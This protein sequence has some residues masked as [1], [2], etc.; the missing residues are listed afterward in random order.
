MAVVLCVSM[1]PVSAFAE[2][3]VA[4]APA[5]EV[6]E[7]T[8][9]PELT[10]PEGTS[11]PEETSEPEET[12]AT[13]AAEAT[14]SPVTA[15]EPETT[16][17]EETTIP[18]ETGDV[19]EPEITWTL[20]G[21]RLP[22]KTSYQAGDPI[23]LTGM[24][25]EL[26]S[27]EGETLTV[28]ADDGITIV[29]GSTECSGIIPV[30]VEYAGLTVEFEILVHM[31]STVGDV[32]QDSSGYPESAHNYSNNMNKT[33]VYS[34]AGAEYLK[35]TFS[36]STLLESGYDNIYI[37]DGA[38]VLLGTYSGSSLA[39]QTIT[40][41]GN[42]VKIRLKTDGSVTKYGFSLTSIYA[43][44]HLVEH[45]PVDEGI[46]TA[47]LCYV[48][49]Y[50][51][52]TC[53][54]CGE[55]FVEP[56]E[57]SACHVYAG[58]FCTGC[59]IPENSIATGRLTDT[60]T[61]AMT[62][63]HVLYVC[64]TGEIPDSPGW[65]ISGAVSAVIS[66][67]V[68]RIGSKAFYGC[69]S[70]TEVSLPASLTAIG[71]YAFYNCA[72][73]TEITIPT[74]VTSLPDYCFQSCSALSRVTLPA[75]LK[76][77]GNYVFQYCTSLTSLVL[78]EGITSLGNSVFYGCSA[79]TELRLPATLTTF[80]YSSSRG[81]LDGSG[82]TRV[83]FGD[84]FTTIPA[85]AL[86]SY[87][88]SGTYASRIREV[89]FED[90]S[91]IT[92]IGSYAFQN[93]TALTEI[94]LP[95]GLKSLGNYAFYNCTSLTAIA[96]PAGVTSLPDYCFQS[97]SALSRVTLPAG[98]KSLGN[99]V[100]PYCTSLTSIVLPEGIT[101]L[102]NSVFYGCS[103]LTELR[104]PATLTTFGRNGARGPL[105]GSGITKVIFGD[106]FTTIPAYALSN[107]ATSGTY[108]SRIREV[109]FEDASRITSIGSYA[110]QN[111]VALTTITIPEAVM[112]IPAYAFY[113]CTSL[114]EA[115]LSERI[116]SIG[117][118][119]F[120]NCTALTELTIPAGMSVGSYAFGYCSRLTEL[121]IG[122]GANIGSYAFQSCSSLR[123][124]VIGSNVTLGSNAFYGVTL[125]GSCGESMTYSLNVS[126]GVLTLS[127]SG[128][129]TDYAPDSPAP[130]TCL[131][132]TITEISFGAD[133]TDIGDY[134]LTG[135]TKLEYLYLPESIQSVGAN[136][137]E[138]CTGLV[139]L[140]I[141]DG[142]SFIGEEAFDGCDN[143]S[144]A[145]FLGDAPVLQDNVFGEAAVEVS[146]PETSA[147]SFV[148][149][150]NKFVQYIW[151]KW[152]DTVPSKDVVILLDVSGSMSGKTSTLSSASTQL[153]KAICGATKKTRVSIVTYESSAT[154]RAGFSTNTHYL[155][156]KVAS[157]NASGGTTYSNA[158]NQAKSLLNSSD[159]D[160]RFVIMF[161]D[162]QPGDSTATINSIASGMRDSGIVMYSVGLGTNSTQRQVLIDVAGSASRYFEA[163]N[164]AGL[165][166]AFQE[167]SE[168]FGKSEYST[169]EMKINDKRVDLFKETYTMVLASGES[170]S[171]YV[172]L[173]TNEMYE[174]VAG[175][176][177]EQNGRYVLRGS[178]G[179]FTN[180]TPASYFVTGSPV[181]LVLLDANGN[182]IERK[183]LL[184][185]FVDSYTIRY[186]MGPD[187]GNELYR[188][189]TFVPGAQITPPAP[190]TRI[191]YDFMGWYSSENCEGMDFFS[192]LELL[193][194]QKLT[195]N[196]TVYA[197][198]QTQATE[199]NLGVDTWTFGN[200]S[201]NFN[202][203]HYEMTTNDVQRLEESAYDIPAE[204]IRGEVY[205]EAA[206]LY[207]L[208]HPTKYDANRNQMVNY[209]GGSCFGMSSAVLLADYGYL[210]ISRF[211]ANGTGGKI[212]NT[213]GAASLVSN[214]NGDHDVGA[215]ESMINFYQT[216][217]SL[218][219]INSVRTDYTR[220]T[221]GTD[222][223]NLQRIIRKLKAENAPVLMTIT[224]LKP[225]NSYGGHAIVAYD[226]E[227]FADRYSFK[228]YDC[229]QFGSRSNP[230]YYTVNV[231]VDGD[232][233]TATC[234]E[235]TSAWSRSGYNRIFFKTA[236]TV[237]EL[238]AL[239][240]LVQPSTL[241]PDT[242]SSAGQNAAQY[243]LMTNYGNFT[244][245][246]GTCSAVIENGELISGDLSIDCLGMVN[247]IDAAPEYWFYLPALNNGDAY[248]ITH[249]VASGNRTAL[250][251]HHQT[252]GFYVT[253]MAIGAG[254]IT[255]GGDGSIRSQYSG[256]VTQE[257][258]VT[259]NN[260]TTPWYTV[261]ISGEGTGFALTPNGD[262][263]SIVSEE[264]TNVDVTAKSS[265]NDLTLTDVP[266]GTAESIVQE[267]EDSCVVVKDGQITAGEVYGY[268]VAFNSQMGTNVPTLTNVPY[269]ALI[270]EPTDPTKTGCIFEGWFV[271]ES[272]TELWD[273]ASDTV[274]G[275]T[276]LYAGWSVNPNYLKAVT[277]RLPGEEDQIVYVPK[278][279]LIP[280]EYAPVDE[281]GNAMV[282]YTRSDFANDPWDFDTDA[283]TGDVVLYG[284]TALCT[285][286]YEP[287]NGAYLPEVQVYAGNLITA[288][289]A[290]MEGR[291][292]CG[293]YTDPG[294][295]EQWDF[296]TDRVTADMTLYAKWVE[297]IIDREGKDTGIS[298]EIVNEA[299]I[300]YTGKAV[301]PAIIVRDNGKVLTEK[302]D[303][304]VSFKNNTAACS[305]DD[306]DVKAN[307]LP[308]IIVQGKGNYK[309]SGKITQYFT[310][311]RADIRTLQIALPTIVTVKSGDKLQTLKPTVS[312]A[313]A[314]VN[315]K[316]YT[317]RYFNDAALTGEVSGITAAGTYY[318]V[319]D[320]TDINLTG[321]SDPIRVLAVTAD[322]LLSK[323]RIT[324]PKSILS[325][326][327]ALSEDAAIQ[328]LV[329][330]VVLNKVTW[331]TAG[332]DLEQ[333]KA[334]FEVTALDADGSFVPQAELGRLLNSVGKKTVTVTAREGNA[335]GLA[336]EISA[337][338]TVK[339]TPL[340]K[341]DFTVTYGAEAA[342][343]VLK[344]VY[345]GSV[346]IP[347]VYTGL[348]EGEDYTVSYL[349][350]KATVPAYRIQNAGSYSLVITGIGSYS[351]SLTYK[352]TIDPMNLA[353]AYGDGRITI[354]S[355]GR[356]VY[357]P[358][359]AVLSPT[360]S[361][362][363]SRQLTEGVD[364]TVKCSG[365]TKVTDSAAMTLTGKG[366]FKGSLSKLPELTYAVE[367]KDLASSDISVTVTGITFKK[368]VVTKVSF[369]VADGAKT[370]PTAQYVSS[371]TDDGDAVTLTIAG[372][373]KNYTGSRTVSLS[374][375]LIKASDKK[376]V[377][378]TLADTGK[379][380]YTGQPI[381]PQVLITDPE[382]R[383]I[384]AGF[385]VSYGANNGIGSGTILVTGRP[386][387]GYCGSVTVK[388]TI[389]P[390]W[391][392]WLFG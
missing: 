93:C 68:T 177:L 379:F 294:F 165:I 73:L 278:G 61:W 322:K 258:K 237:E 356:A 346:Q 214:S 122:D 199:L 1:L 363:G 259:H 54:I 174:A 235:W 257:M 160:I 220:H 325:T 22:D 71:S 285:V 43:G 287:G 365:N 307:K 223:E 118:Y 84:G 88:T 339:G 308:Q 155:S 329:E 374:R 146:Y 276:I 195:G 334:L 28:T 16:S 328:A 227:E 185:E 18:E 283:I 119:A 344:T 138:G 60:I 194:S 48:D 102:G 232:T 114:K 97:C 101:S 255:I 158:L 375:D 277:F 256:T 40:V 244:I 221:E 124:I 233:Y 104:L 253:H 79:L 163:S 175:Y 360:V 250:I 128:E 98:L 211:P 364:Y 49:G 27:S 274:T 321:T 230:I 288:P 110:F 30:T 319:L 313:L 254:T 336:G 204:L 141:P 316:E 15:P 353:D 76:S 231:A 126:T 198:W 286:S 36:S 380:Y 134:A 85:Y 318:A 367:A 213:I 236:M 385:T 67:G 94:T 242:T 17:P 251:S 3:A 91:R 267:S 390:K 362:N 338:I 241:S 351:G 52:H 391:M 168:N 188:E 149:A 135:C 272:C 12:E 368:D 196:T 234:P 376:Q 161:S 340:N 171:F 359:G 333:F 120:Y 281:N 342:K 299:G 47:P 42:T 348:V 373:D 284:K 154:T 74:G 173:G 90:A 20:V 157:L 170:V 38:D 191:G 381:K 357:S 315:A 166:A 151:S 180:L 371:F 116:T 103:A 179:E 55:S 14:V 50:T 96:I 25:L 178:S 311:H 117:S 109:V 32:L 347:A 26:E 37:Y 247:E 7:T 181:Y 217:Q 190:P 369:S 268:S 46:Y 249:T 140:E 150:W 224:L 129:M 70:L 112:A 59:G 282:W 392:K 6:P 87:A 264:E 184:L 301:I 389:L 8:A 78:P 187:M 136:S 310:I 19:T 152:D 202:C 44:L 275:D 10:E 144:Q 225:N 317:V 228:V 261:K 77:L 345:T 66:E 21:Y 139:Y 218:G 212:Y 384:S 86:S 35:L 58:G 123:N 145:V 176:A 107:Y 327:E 349:R 132:S 238:M 164:I 337:K 305:Q 192:A 331:L 215:I 133:V 386:D 292:L 33:W 243:T 167:L 137:F 341:K 366:N 200:S 271:D 57:G 222:S 159:A 153:I 113:Y 53:W 252:N 186:L 83:I 65:S 280:A 335:E 41:T 45:E 270:E 273:F 13:D 105:D 95:E 162:G 300:V 208:R 279:E 130:W 169:V 5:M 377:K 239:P 56:D 263:V 266:V 51:T 147:N 298:I 80:G 332:E 323:A 297:N 172:T 29:D 388:F 245:S 125:S 156:K 295:A 306:P 69:T 207:D 383:D 296:E 34:C 303:Y 63:E 309:S 23:D 324:P 148:R 289:E 193:G 142:V 240:I 352:F 358:S 350:G 11:V 100:F 372:T 111:C 330:K 229:S 4:E 131:A 189:E 115:P 304:T 293:W 183:E 269:G 24:E 355:P 99:Y 182:V 210:S 92:S 121:T 89:V 39:N 290:A 246:D 64:G 209:W 326:G 82:V 72:S 216:R 108:A 203:T 382:G 62:G 81:P 312:T 9:V 262:S 370:V 106:G 197:K 205:S 248:A 302:T 2:E 31:V 260:L 387:M 127:G 143:L 201:S 354:T 378:I 320:A 75:G 314:K 343:P 361:F 219:A 265:F 291:T 206:W 226:L